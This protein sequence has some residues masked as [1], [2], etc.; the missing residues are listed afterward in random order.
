MKQIFASILTFFNTGI[1]KLFTAIILISGTWF[2]TINSENISNKIQQLTTT[3]IDEK[4]EKPIETDLEEGNKNGTLKAIS[5][6]IPTNKEATWIYHNNEERR[7]INA[8][9]LGR[10]YDIRNID[11]INWSGETLKS[12]QRASA[13]ALVRDDSRRPARHNN[14]D[15]VVPKGVVFTSEIIGDSEAESKFAAT[16]FEF[17]NDVLSSYK[18]KAKVPMKGSAKVSAAFHDVNSTSSSNNT[19]FAFS[20]MYKQ[21]YKLDLYFDD[22]AHEHY[23]DMR[24]WQGVNELGDE[25]SV[26]EFI[27]KFGTHYASTTY[28]GGNFFQRRSI[29]QSQYAYY[30]SSER[31]FKADVEGTIKKV[32]FDVGTVQQS[33]NS[34]GETERVEMSAAKIFTVGG[35]LNQNEPELWSTSVLENLAVVKVKLTRLSD[36]LTTKNFPNVEDIKTKKAILEAAIL[37]AEQEA[38]ANQSK[39]QSHNFFTKKPVKFRLTATYIKCRGH[40]KGEPGQNSEYFGTINIGLFN[41]N[42]SKIISKPVFNKSKKNKVT[43]SKNQ[44]YDL[45]KSITLT[46]SPSDLAKGYASVYGS[47]KEIDWSDIPLSSLSQHE[48]KCKISYR[49]ALDVPVKKLV[50]MTTEY[51]DNVELHYVLERI[52]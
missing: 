3:Q 40:G 1:G 26:D 37:K 15:Y 33:R 30:E 34:L 20:K 14:K 51:G 44:A 18:V 43:L 6:R 12:G 21:Y 27:K 28:Y 24:F 29:S 19:L 10:C 4:T 35:D 48:S 11:P 46:I 45:N 2:I 5:P 23:I 47:L 32:K 50:S 17:E 42:G 25:L 22:P 36:L 16:S 39:Q 9:G 41:R 13:I 31:D 52:N 8:E 49:N 7:E 38:T